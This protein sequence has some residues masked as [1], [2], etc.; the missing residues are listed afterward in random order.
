VLKAQSIKGVLCNLSIADF[1]SLVQ[2]KMPG[3]PGVHPMYKKRRRKVQI[4]PKFMLRQLAARCRPSP[5]RHLLL[6]S[7]RKM[8]ILEQHRVEPQKHFTE[9]S[10]GELGLCQES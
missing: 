1:V 10:H 6:N 5:A 2:E 4:L 7:C 8:I 9:G 3:I